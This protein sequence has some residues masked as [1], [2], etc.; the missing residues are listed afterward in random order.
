MVSESEFLGSL[1]ETLGDAKKTIEKVVKDADATAEKRKELKEAFKPKVDASAIMGTKNEV[2]KGLLSTIKRG[3]EFDPPRILLYGIDGIGKT[4]W[5]SEAPNPIFLPIEDGVSQIGAA[6]FPISREF[7]QVTQQ[8]ETLASE[9]HEFQSVVLDSTDALERLI[10][11]QVCANTGATHIEKALGGYGKGYGLALNI[12]QEVVAAL[13]RCRAKGMAIILL[14]HPK[15]EK[16]EDPEFATYDRFSPRLHKL[17]DA[18]LREQV[19]CTLFASRRMILR[20]DESGKTERNI[21]TAVGAAGG[22]RFIRC[23]GTPAV[24]AKNRYDL[25]ETIPMVKGQGWSEFFKYYMAF[26]NSKK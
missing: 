17:A 21:A 24:V 25:P 7:P 16:F 2:P 26:M 5:A 14:A 4:T 15:T 18:Y 11:K 10:W 9:A 23:I 13:D 8:L 12:W 6:R 3:V 19:D 20:S 1:K 22:E